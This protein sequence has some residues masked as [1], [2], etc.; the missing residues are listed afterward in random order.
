MSEEKPVK[1]PVGR[2][3]K[4]KPEYCDRIVEMAKETGAGP[5]E[6]ASEFDIDRTTLYD[7]AAAHED[8]STALSRAKVHE[9]AWWERAGRK[10]MYLEKFNALVWKTSVQA[11]FRQDYTERTQTELSG[12]NGAPVQVESKTLDARALAPEQREALKEILL[13]AKASA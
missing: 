11:R 2:P 13:A 7:W 12:P 1:R 3:S 5:A 10:G 4:Y 8:F 6:Y 9:Q